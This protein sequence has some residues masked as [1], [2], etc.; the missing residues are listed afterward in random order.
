MSRQYGKRIKMPSYPKGNRSVIYRPSR[1]RKRKVHKKESEEP[2]ETECPSSSRR[3]LSSVDV[4]DAEVN[5]A[6]TYR[7][8]EF[9][10]VFN[11]LSQLLI[12]RYCK[13][14]VKFTEAGARGF[15]FKIVVSCSCKEST[16]IN[17]GPFINTGFEINRRLVFVM[18]LLGIG[19]EGVN[20]FAGLMDFGTGL[21]NTAY[22]GIVNQVYNAA[23]YVFEVV[24]K[25]AVAEEEKLNEKK[26]KPK[27]DFHVS[28]DG[29]WKKRGFSSLLGVT[30]LIGNLTGKAIDLIVKSA[31]CKSCIAWKSKEG[32]AEYT[33]WYETH[34]E[35]CLAN[36]SGSAGK[37]EVDSIKEMFSQSEEKYGV[38]YVNYIGDG[39]SKTFQGI[40]N[41]NPYGD[42]C[43]VIKSECIG[44]I[45]KRM[46]TRLRNVRKDKKLGGRGKLTDV[47]IKKITRYYGLAIR[48]NVNS[49]QDMRTAIQATFDHLTSTD[50]KPKHQNCPAGADSWCKW[51][52]AESIGKTASYKHP[53]PLHPDVEKNILSIFK[54]LSKDE[55]LNK[56]LGGYTQNANESFNATVWRLAPKHL[57]SGAKIVNIAAFIAAA[58]FNEG[59]NAILMIII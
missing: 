5:N 27:S 33:E 51:R 16:C 53:S 9:V 48:R 56:C 8:I 21:S 15:G 45:E 40:L 24:C 41:L 10:S 7:I 13:K 57:H 36:H 47:L 44:H 12:C 19:R 18:R 46:G 52:K 50:A 11:M 38:R 28:G 35:E 25:K 59:Y 1:P 4:F 26:E 58:V 17:S 43:P 23:K 30:T 22:D 31:F 6:H 42:E 37:M 54:D 29:S 20:L 49:V 34:H 39:D 32:T 55:L 14:D 3:K 2:E